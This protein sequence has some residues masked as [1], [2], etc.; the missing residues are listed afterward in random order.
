MLKTVEPTGEMKTSGALLPAIMNMAPA[1]YWSKLSRSP[2][3][4]NAGI[5]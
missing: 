5:K 4:Y 3:S 2:M 1:T